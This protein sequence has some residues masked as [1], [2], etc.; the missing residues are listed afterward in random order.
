MN[1][2]NTIVAGVAAIAAIVIAGLMLGVLPQQRAAAEARDEKTQIEQNNQ[3][4]TTQLASLRKQKEDLSGLK[5]DL[6]DL[7]RQIP[8]S[9]DLASVTRV[10]VN[11]LA[12]PGRG[13][14][15]TLVSITP[16]VPP[17]PFVAREQLTPEIGLPEAVP[18]APKGSASTGEDKATPAGTFQQIPLGITATSPDVRA[19]FQFVDWLNNGPRLLAVHH[20]Q[21]ATNGDA[22]GESGEDPVTVTVIGAAFL[23]P[24]AAR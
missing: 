15:S 12:S 1:R 3:L 13:K 18:V 24:T 10:I 8:A 7:R 20:V 5:G 11:A 2:Q 14:G 9:A 17:I 19:A 22:G 4:L 21:I 23:Q 16:Q 6:A